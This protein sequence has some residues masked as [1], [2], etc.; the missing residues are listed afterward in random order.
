MKYCRFASDRQRFEA[1]QQS[2]ILQKTRRFDEEL[3]FEHCMRSSDETRHQH[4]R[5]HATF[6]RQLFIDCDNYDWAED[7]E[8]SDFRAFKLWHVGLT[9]SHLIDLANVR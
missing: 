8:S 9:A 5:D 6:M 1:M 7:V 2:G 4:L 3:D